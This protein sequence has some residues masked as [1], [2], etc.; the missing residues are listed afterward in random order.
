MISL[1]SGLRLGCLVEERLSIPFWCVYPLGQQI[2]NKCYF[3]YIAL[4]RDRQGCVRNFVVFLTAR[5]GC[6]KKDK[7]WG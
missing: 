4:C 3:L 1:V 5:A 7:I 6:I 2:L